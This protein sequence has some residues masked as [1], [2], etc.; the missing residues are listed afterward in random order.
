MDSIGFVVLGTP[1]SL[2]AKGRSKQVW[3]AKVAAAWPLGHPAYVGD[4]SARLVF[5]FDSSTD[6]DV[7]N[8]VKPIL[9]ALTGLAY[10]DDSQVMNVLAQKRDLN[11]VALRDAPPEILAALI[12]GE[13]FVYVSI[14]E[15]DGELEF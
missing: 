13:D 2:Q 10:A 11:S 12:R 3:R 15:A 9:D 7:D 6:L 1:K 4:V 8:I 14:S 5:F